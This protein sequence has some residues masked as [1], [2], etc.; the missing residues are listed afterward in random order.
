MTVGY[1]WH[2]NNHKYL[3]V[4]SK[5][6]ID[7]QT[8]VRQPKMCKLVENILVLHISIIVSPSFGVPQ[9][10][11]CNNII[12]HKT[13]IHKRVRSAQTPTDRPDIPVQHPE[14][15]RVHFKRHCT[16]DLVPTVFCRSQNKTHTVNEVKHTDK[17][18]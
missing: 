6:Q 5:I 16:R 14:L 3:F 2:Y 12:D 13:S 18:S 15:V 10:I 4:H 9:P 7:S 11:R 8:T 1:K 17:F